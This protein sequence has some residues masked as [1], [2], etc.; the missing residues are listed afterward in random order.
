MNVKAK[1]L[2]KKNSKQNSVA[3]YKKNERKL[4]Q[5]YFRYVKIV[6]NLEIYQNNFLFRL[7]GKKSFITI[8]GERHLIKSSNNY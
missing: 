2:K 5:V 3:N 7:K 1:I 6:E 4:S 8:V